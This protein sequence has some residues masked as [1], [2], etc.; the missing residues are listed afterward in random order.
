MQRYH[1]QL[2]ALQYS[3]ERTRQ[4]D[5]FRKRIQN[6]IIHRK[7]VQKKLQDFPAVYTYIMDKFQGIDLSDLA[8]FLSPAHVIQQNGW[9]QIGGCYVKET[10]TILVKD[11]IKTKKDKTRKGKFNKLMA[12]QCSVDVDVEDV[13]VHEVIH[14]VSH[15]M[16]RA[17]CKFEHMEEEFVYCNCIDFY[18]QKGMTE[19]DIVD[20]NLLP[21]CIN[22]IYSSRS[23]F[24]SVI[25]A[26]GLSFPYVE[27]LD[28]KKYIRFCNRHAENLVPAIKSKAQEKG[29]QMIAIYKQY[30]SRMNMTDE[31]PEIKDPS[32]IRFASLELDNAD[33]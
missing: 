18:K 27:S 2:W 19:D 7:T 22:D 16:N 24:K 32:S 4:L 17:S 20:N 6:I 33:L 21:F 13:V 30:G 29:H 15:R 26:A 31:A 12:K 3:K 23:G 9:P 10:N 1:Q 5:R 25:C 28:E 11:E 8:I 14:A